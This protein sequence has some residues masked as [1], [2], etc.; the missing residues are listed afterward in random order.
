[1]DWLARAQGVIS[2]KYGWSLRLKLKKR[3]IVHLSP[4]TDLSAWPLS[5]VT[6]QSKLRAKAISQVRAQNNPYARI[7]PWGPVCG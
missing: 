5:S 7:T 2:P 4:C 3:T 1:V 6:V